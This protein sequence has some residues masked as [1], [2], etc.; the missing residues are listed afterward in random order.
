MNRF[1]FVEIPGFPDYSINEFGFVISYKRTTPKLLRVRY[2]GSGY[3]RY[4]LNGKDL[5]I[6]RLLAM[7][8]IKNWDPKLEVNHIDGDILNNSLENLEMVTHKENMEHMSKVG[9]ANP[10]CGEKSHLSKLK[11]YEV[12]QIVDLLTNT[13]YTRREIAMFYGVSGST[14]GEIKRGA[15]WRRICANT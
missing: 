13:S 14:I 6:H 10:V 9:R 2:D 1:V 8:F 5:S 4:N 7:T 12:F 11:N 3:K 15:S